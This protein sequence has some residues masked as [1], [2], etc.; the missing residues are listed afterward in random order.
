MKV[1][2]K[3]DYKTYFK[4]FKLS[5]LMQ[6]DFDKLLKK[7]SIGIKD[8]VD[9]NNKIPFGPDILDLIRLL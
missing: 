2:K 9:P 6:K 3:L 7:K 8:R 4:K 5:K 1:F